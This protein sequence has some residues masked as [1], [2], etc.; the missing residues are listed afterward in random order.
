VKAPHIGFSFNFTDLPVGGDLQRLRPHIMR[1]NRLVVYSDYEA[2]IYAEHFAMPLDRFRVVRWTQDP[3][4]V[5]RTGP[6]PFGGPYLCA[7]GG[8]GRDYRTLVEAA[9]ASG[10][11]LAI[12]ARPQSL[13]GL[14]L[15]D[16]VRSFSNLPLDVTWEMASNSAGVVVPLFDLTTRCGVL[17]IVSAAQLGLPTVTARTHTLAEYLDGHV[18]GLNY[19]PGDVE[20]CACAMRTLF[21]NAARYREKARSYVDGN[22]A[23]FDR[24]IWGQHLDSI[25]DE[26]A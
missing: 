12:I 20:D 19:A 2:R 5:A 10:L 26:F 23:F 18:A 6:R 24:A 13:A 14:D 25:L 4:P 15:P 11:P 3:P 7:V 22:R 21:D 17:T 9:R 1:V 8:E 16:N